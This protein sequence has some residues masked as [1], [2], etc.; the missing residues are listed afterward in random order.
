VIT[1]HSLNVSSVLTAT[2]NSYGYRQISTPHKINT[3]ELIDKK[4]AQLI[5]SARGTPVPNLVQIHPL[6]ASWQ[7]GKM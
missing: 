6:G 7:T 5:T 4:S 1:N 2:F 3:P